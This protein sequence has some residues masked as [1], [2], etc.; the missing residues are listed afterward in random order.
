MTKLACSALL[1]SAALELA[2]CSGNQRVEGDIVFQSSR[3]GNFEI[4]TM[5]AEGENV[6]RI[7]N[8]PTNDVTPAWSPDG[9]MIA[10]ASDRDGSW[11][12]Y[13][14]R[15]DGTELRQVTR[16]QGTNTA[17]AWVDGGK[18]LLFVSTRDVINGDLYRM[19]PDGSGVERLTA[20]S[21]V[22]DSP[23]MLPDES[24]VLMTVN[25]KGRNRIA[26][27]SLKTKAVTMLTAA[28][29]NSMMPTVSNDGARVLFV[30]D[31]DGNDEIYFM[32]AAGEHPTR[33]TVNDYDD[34]SPAFTSSADDILLSARGGIYLLSLKTRTQ[35]L[36]SNKGD[37][38]P[39]FHPR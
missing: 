16:N 5:N 26:S 10:F 24:A 36:I 32:T 15:A 34:I 39:S 28:E 35:R 38:A 27:Y 17:P 29:Y 14:V 13:T 22:K 25:Q 12:I 30:S 18:K 6:R 9:E 21:L 3:D 23:A 2:G 11:D 37:S 33:L 19:N 8:S 4:Y 31:R 7:T 1:L 20:D